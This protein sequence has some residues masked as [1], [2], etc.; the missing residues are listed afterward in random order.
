M[1]YS[2]P[3]MKFLQIWIITVQSTNY[4]PYYYWILQT[5]IIK[6]CSKYVSFGNSW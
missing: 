2:N 5:Q 4:K 6:K 3:I 1:S